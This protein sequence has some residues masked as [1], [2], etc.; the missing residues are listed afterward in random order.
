MVKKDLNFSL[1]TKIL[2]N[3]PLCIFLSK[4]S[5]YR[6]Y[7]DGTKCI[8]FLI[9]DDEFLEEYNEIWGKFGKNFGLQKNLI[10]NQYTIKTSKS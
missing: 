7:F 9:K 3:R 4:M 8:S 1:A 6:R 2:K 5:A 10:V